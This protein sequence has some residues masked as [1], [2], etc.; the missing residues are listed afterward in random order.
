VKVLE[1]DLDKKSMICALMRDETEHAKSRNNDSISFKSTPSDRAFT[2]GDVADF[3]K[4]FPSRTEDDT[5]A[6][7][8]APA[9]R[10]A[11]DTAIPV[12]S[13]SA[14]DLPVPDVETEVLETPDRPEESV[15]VPISNGT[16]SDMETGAEATPVVSPDEDKALPA[17]VQASTGGSVVDDPA[18]Y[19]AEADARADEMRNVTAKPDAESGATDVA[20]E[21][22]AAAATPPEAVDRPAVDPSREE[23]PPAV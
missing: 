20:S 6:G 23:P 2:L 22:E 14:P 5:T 13:V 9:E 18:M 8:A 1:I 10:A 11:P 3:S 7:Q 19:T 16:P 15:A 4:L 21:S 17:A 12:E